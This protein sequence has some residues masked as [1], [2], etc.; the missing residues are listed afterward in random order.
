MLPYGT[1]VYGCDKP[2]NT[3][4]YSTI[5]KKNCEF[6]TVWYRTVRYHTLSYIQQIIPYRTVPVST[7]KNDI[8]CCT[9]RY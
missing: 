8:I 7:V 1:V 3:V 5:H 4:R 9:E 2:Y 6:G